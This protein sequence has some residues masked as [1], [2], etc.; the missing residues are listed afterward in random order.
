MHV[1]EF[2]LKVHLLVGGKPYYD[3]TRSKA[4]CPRC[5]SAYFLG[6]DQEK[7]QRIHHK[8]QTP[9]KLQKQQMCTVQNYFIQEVLLRTVKCER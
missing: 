1:V 6:S 3:Y 8:M 4:Y 9:A 2:I 5:G 7:T